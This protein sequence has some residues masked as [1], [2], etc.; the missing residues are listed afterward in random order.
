MARGINELNTCH[1]NSLAECGAGLPM[2]GGARALSLRWTVS[3]KEPLIEMRHS[4]R[5]VP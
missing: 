5:S 1:P 3:K 2:I 4:Q